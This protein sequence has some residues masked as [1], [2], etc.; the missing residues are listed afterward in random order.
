MPR[1]EEGACEIEFHSFLKYD[2]LQGT[3][4]QQ[5]RAIKCC[6]EPVKTVIEGVVF[7][8]LAFALD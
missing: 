5:Y 8:P 7:N 2:D 6:A 3:K 1:Y 4:W